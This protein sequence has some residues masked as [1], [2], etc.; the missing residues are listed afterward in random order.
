MTTVDIHANFFNTFLKPFH[1]PE[2]K[3]PP[4]NHAAERAARMFSD[5]Q[6]TPQSWPADIRCR[7]NTP[8]AFHAKL[9]R[10]VPT[11]EKLGFFADIR[12]F[13]DMM[14]DRK[15]YQKTFQT[16]YDQP[17]PSRTPY[18]TLP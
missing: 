10:W 6:Q 13:L 11:N 16:W 14:D 7:E 2:E 4:I 9:G 18:I 8:Y 12:E 17:R 15:D 1:V 3:E 5:W